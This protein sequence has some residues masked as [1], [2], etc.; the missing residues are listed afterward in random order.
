MPSS[1]GGRVLV[2]W[3]RTDGR[4]AGLRVINS[5]DAVF[6][7]QNKLETYKVFKRAD[8]PHPD[9]TVDVQTV[10]DWLRSDKTVLARS[11]LRGSKGAGIVLIRN[12]RPSVQQRVSDIPRAPLYVTYRPKRREYRIHVMSAEVIGVQQ[13][14]KRRE[15]NND[16]V[17][18]QIRNY[19]N[20]W[21]Y[22]REELE[23]PRDA[24]CEAAVK[25]VKALGLDFGAV[26]VGENDKQGTCCVYEVNT[27]P[28]LEGTT[29]TEY[30][31]AIVNFV[32][33]K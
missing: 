24:T 10:L 22:C 1:K 18:Y 3:G 6:K 8:I 16:D 32:R 29:L 12:S 30:A 9:W 33:T 17:D 5:P 7:A 15:V 31:E 19:D 13:K 11:I 21:V 26:D 25:A 2:N 14:R 27:A 4:V 23:A 20:G 28:G